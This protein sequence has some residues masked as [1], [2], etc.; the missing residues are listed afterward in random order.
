MT[1]PAFFLDTNICIYALKG[2][3]PSIADRLR[4]SLPAAI[5]VPSIV[6]AE[7]LFGAHKSDRPRGTVDAVHAFLSPFEIVPFGDDAASCYATIRAA[8]EKRGKPVGPNDL[9]IAATVLA[10]RGTLIT[11]NVREFQ[12]VAGLSIEDWTK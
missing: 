3:Y 11:H 5:K 4:A 6:N 10:H 1:R 7:L 8:L 12:R 9:V 2:R